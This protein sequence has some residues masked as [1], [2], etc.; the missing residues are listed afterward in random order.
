M[1]YLL[2][3]MENALVMAQMARQWMIDAAA[4]DA[5]API[6]QPAS[7]ILIRKTITAQATIHTVE[8]A[9]VNFMGER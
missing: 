3:E 9:I 4:S 1:P 2:S 5:F 7:A 8:K 6:G